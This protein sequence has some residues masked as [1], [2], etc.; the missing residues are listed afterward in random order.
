M[1]QG[2]KTALDSQNPVS[3]AGSLSF[4]SDGRYRYRIMPTDEVVVDDKTTWF[5]D[6]V[7]TDDTGQAL[8]DFG[9]DF[10][11][12]RV[13]SKKLLSYYRTIDDKSEPV[14]AGLPVFWYQ[15]PKTGTFETI[16]KELETVL[17][18]WLEKL[19]GKSIKPVKT[20]TAGEFMVF[21]PAWEKGSDIPMWVLA[22]KDDK[23]TIYVCE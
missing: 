9:I 10:G 1:K 4:L 23:R 22:S 20:L 12:I 5:I 3:V 18:E 13:S 2:F 16:A 15:G 11:S 17:T 21:N 14:V 6:Q 19:R 8:L 7:G